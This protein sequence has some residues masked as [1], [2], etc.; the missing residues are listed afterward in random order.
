LH[1]PVPVPQQLPEI[2]ILPT[3]HPRTAVISLTVLKGPLAHNHEE[4]WRW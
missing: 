2:S 3:R 1:H 4:Q